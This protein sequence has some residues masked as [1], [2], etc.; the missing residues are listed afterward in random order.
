MAPS[1]TK[2]IVEPA[3]SSRLAPVATGPHGDRVW[4]HRYRHTT[5][6]WTL[7]IATHAEPGSG[8]LSL[9]GFRIAPEERTS[10]P[11]F[12]PVREAIELAVGME[13]KVHWSRLLRIGGP[14][15]QRDFARIV[16]GKCVL[17]PSADA[18]VGCP[19]DFALLDFA[20][21]CLTDC[22][23]S[24]GIHIT[25]GQDLGHGV[26]SDG[27]TQSLD[28]LNRGF[29]GSVV[30]DT[31]LP[32]AE[33]N[34]QVLRGMLRAFEIP[35]ARAT[36]GLVGIGHIGSRVLDHLC[37]DGARLLAVESNATRRAEIA[38]RGI[39]VWSPESKVDFLREPMDALVLNASGGSL[40]PAA[41]TA[42]TRNARLRIICGSENLVMPDPRGANELLEAHKAYCPTELGGMMGYLTA[43]EEYLAYLE[44]QPF[45]VDAVLDAA[46]LLETVG[47]EGA[48]RVRAREF[49]IS[50]EDAVRAY[51]SSA[52]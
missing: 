38:N 46:R 26:M 35:V 43:V 23:K 31:S 28:Y 45:R 49:A 24:A 7:A 17:E 40:D 37:G 30:A 10:L 22:A 20:I 13:Q 47:Y 4:V 48:K 9:G 25:T 2:T 8:K 34:Y 1:F 16:G 15:T 6:R 29:P 19:R 27:R 12:D 18:R 21:E 5:E 14:L 44:G 39:R 3:E 52:A 50:F 36:V 33:G 11:G 51:A 41:V 32:T 42:C